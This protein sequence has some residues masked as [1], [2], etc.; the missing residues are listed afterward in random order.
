MS[1]GKPVMFYIDRVGAGRSLTY[2]KPLD[3]SLRNLIEW[4]SAVRNWYFLYYHFW[5][6]KIFTPC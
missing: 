2:D 1:D 5:H 4:G 3:I 6:G